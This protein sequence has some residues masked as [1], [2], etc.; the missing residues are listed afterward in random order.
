MFTLELL[1]YPATPGH[2]RPPLLFVHG[3]CHG[4]WCWEPSYMPFFSSQGWDCYAVSLRGHGASAGREQLHAFGLEDY[5]SDLLQ[6]AA[7]ITEQCGRRPI[8]IGHSMG[9]AVV[10]MALRIA[11]ERFSAAVLLAS[12]PPQGMTKHENLGL[13]LTHPLNLL[14]LKRLMDG[15]PLGPQQVQ[16]LPFFDRAISREDA[17]IYAGLLQPESN[18]AKAGLSQLQ[19]PAFTLTIPLL[20]IGSARDRLFATDAL[21]RTAAFYGTTAQVLAQGCHDLMLDPDWKQSASAIA[22]WLQTLPIDQ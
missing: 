10:Q 17:T 14:A 11:T 3:A 1:H 22:A 16:R 9:G 2:T 19:I 18:R 13:L 21:Q 4:A 12:M 20:V 5:V 8:L 7:R 15:K 6:T